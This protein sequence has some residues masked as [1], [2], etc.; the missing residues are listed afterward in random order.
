MRLSNGSMSL[1]LLPSHTPSLPTDPTDQ[2]KRI[3]SESAFIRMTP[4]QP[5]Y[6]RL[7]L[8]TDPASPTLSPSPTTNP[9]RPPTPLDSEN[10]T[11]HH[12][13]REGRDPLPPTAKT[14][15]KQHDKPTLPPR[16]LHGNN[17][18]PDV[19]RHP[20]PYPLGVRVFQSWNTPY[21]PLTPPPSPQTLQTS[22]KE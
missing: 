11:H 17:V 8:P 22:T 7:T 3:K 20:T 15:M 4:T 1:F 19:H 2:H 10:T 9:A 5:P 13:G 6:T 21:S 12:P 16:S 18:R 14:K